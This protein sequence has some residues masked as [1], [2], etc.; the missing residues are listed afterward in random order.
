[1]KETLGRN[2]GCPQG[3]AGKLAGA[4][5]ESD[6]G[7]GWCVRERRKRQVDH[8]AVPGPLGWGFSYWGHHRS[9]ACTA[10]QLKS[11][12]EKYS[13]GAKY[14]LRKLKKLRVSQSTFGCE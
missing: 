6:S 13:P 2:W 8:P 4:E 1:M 9:S 14:F 12:L 7:E 11:M 3:L 5:D 10:F